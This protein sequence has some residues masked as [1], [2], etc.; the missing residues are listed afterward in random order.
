VLQHQPKAK[1]VVLNLDYFMFDPAADLV[2]DARFYPYEQAN[3]NFIYDSAESSNFFHKFKIF[4]ASI[5]D[6][7]IKY[8]GLDG[9]L[10]PNHETNIDYKGFSPKVTAVF[11][12]PSGKRNGKGHIVS[13]EKGYQILENFILLCKSRKVKLAFILAPFQINYPPTAY[14]ENYTPIMNRVFKMAANYSVPILDFS[15]A[16]LNNKMQFFNN[17][18]HL[19][20]AGADIYSTMA[21]EKIKALL[22]NVFQ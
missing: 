7:N 13:S 17:S 1:M 18:S 4:D 19:N 3:C 6:D 12:E 10:R 14:F 2:K 20:S 8:I 5:Y 16:E 15:N 21:A 11:E 22:L 9:L